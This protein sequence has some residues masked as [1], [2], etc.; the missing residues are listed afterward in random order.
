[1][2]A[3]IAVFVNVISSS[4]DNNMLN[5]QSAVIVYSEVIVVTSHYLHLF[6]SSIAELLMIW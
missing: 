1:M 6:V 5:I 4:I 3:I 2:T